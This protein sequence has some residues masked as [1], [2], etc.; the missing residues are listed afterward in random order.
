[1]NI[2]ALVATLGVD[3]SGLAVA[4]A[5]MRKFE[6]TTNASITSINTR[7][8]TT[9]AAFKKVGR[10][11]SMYLTAPILLVGGA[12]A[13]MHM[14]FE[15]SMTKIIGLVG[16]ARHQVEAWTEDIIKRAPALAKTPES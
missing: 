5:S 8:A 1:M 7:L 12:A 4:S 10:N 6:A 15:A 16:V 9:G 11:M 2:G 3:A 14:G 13:K